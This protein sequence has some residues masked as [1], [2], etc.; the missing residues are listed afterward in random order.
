M[1]TEW[2][3]HAVNP[4]T[5]FFRGEKAVWVLL[6]PDTLH[7][8]AYCCTASENDVPKPETDKTLERLRYYESPEG[9]AE[10][11]R[12]ARTQSPQSASPPDDGATTSSPSLLPGHR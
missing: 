2:K 3:L 8:L 4:T 12:L 5:G 9:R 10:T 7:P 1:S 11:L 6:D